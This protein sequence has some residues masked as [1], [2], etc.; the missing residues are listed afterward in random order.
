MLV[1]GMSGMPEKV[2]ASVE[3]L[4]APLSEIGYGAGKVMLRLGEV[5]EPP[6]WTVPPLSAELGR[7]GEVAEALPIVHGVPSRHLRAVL[8]SGWMLDGGSIS[9]ACVAAAMAAS[10][11]VVAKV[12]PAPLSS[13][14]TVVATWGA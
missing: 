9:R 11:I 12:A 5:I 13:W 3:T 1:N 14:S 7:N 2:M 8:T 6:S 10:V 4:I